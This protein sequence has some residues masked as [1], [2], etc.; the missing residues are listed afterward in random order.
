MIAIIKRSFRGS[1]LEG[2]L[3]LARLSAVS[4]CDA[5]FRGGAVT[6]KIGNEL[7]QKGSN[8]LKNLWRSGPAFINMYILFNHHE[9]TLQRKKLVQNRDISH[10]IKDDRSVKLHNCQVS[11]FSKKKNIHRDNKSTFRWQASDS[12][13]LR[14]RKRLIAH[15]NIF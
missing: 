10:N 15:Q 3:C 14:W 2:L 13:I 7:D 1:I 11:Q 9:Q 8:D 6:G 5:S 12:T 4:A